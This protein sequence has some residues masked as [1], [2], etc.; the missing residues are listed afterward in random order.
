M[1]C[2]CV[3]FVALVIQHAM[4]MRHIVT[5]EK[6]GLQYFS[7]LSHKGRIFE[8]KNTEHKICFDFLYIVC[9]QHSSF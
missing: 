9:L 5:V 8:K 6:P 2:V 7:T 4:R 3:L 1:F